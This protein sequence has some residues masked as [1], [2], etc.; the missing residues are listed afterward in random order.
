MEVRMNPSSPRIRTPRALG[1]GLLSATALLLGA[2][3]FHAHAACPP[4]RLFD[5]FTSYGTG[6]GPHEIVLD[7][8]NEDGILDLLTA[9]GP[10]NGSAPGAG[11]FTLRLGRGS[12]GVGDGSYGVPVNYPGGVRLRFV[13]AADFDEDGILDLAATDFLNSC[14]VVVRGQGTGGVGNGSFGPP[15]P[16]AVGTNPFGM[17]LG[18]FNEDGILDLAVM[19]N[20]SSNLSILLGLG[21]GGV[22]N[23]NFGPPT[24]YTL[25]T[26]PA[27]IATGDFNED[28]ITD[29]AAVVYGANRVS[30]LLGNGAGGVG[31]GTFAA[32]V[33]YTTGGQPFDVIAE[34]FNEDGIADLATGN[35]GGGLSILLGNGAG[36]VGNGTFA[37][38]T[39][40]SAGG[41]ASN[42]VAADW[43]EDGILD[44]ATINSVADAFTVVL[45]G[46]S[47]G[48]GD[49]TFGSGTNYGVGD[50]PD[51]L[52]ARDVNEDGHMDLLVSD[53]NGNDVR[54]FF[55]ACVPQPNLSNAPALDDVR[56]VR[57][58]QGGK[59]FVVW[60]R[61]VLDG[62]TGTSVTQYQ[63]WRRIAPDA[64]PRLSGA[65]RTRI[66]AGAITYWE[67][68]ATLPAHRL[69]GYGYTAATTRDSLPG[70]NPYTAFFVSAL[71]ADPNV[72]YDSNVD[73]G[74]SVDNLAPA[75]AAPFVGQWLPEGVALHWGASAAPDFARYEIHRGS[76]PSFVPSAGNLIAS[77]PDTGYVDSD[78]ATV[79]HYKL[80]V[81][82]VHEN[83]STAA[84]ASPPAA[85]PVTLAFHEAIVETGA[86]TLSWAVDRGVAMIATLE[87]RRATTDWAPIAEIV[88]DGQGN[89]VYTDRSV[90]DGGRYAYR[91][92]WTGAEGAQQSDEV[93]VDVP[94]Y[95]L[96]FA[97]RMPNPARGG[98]LP[99]ELTLASGGSGRLE[100]FTAT[101]RRVFSTSVDGVGPHRVDVG[102]GV[103]L[104]SG[105]YWLRLA[106]DGR[107]VR[108]KAVL[109]P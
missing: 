37:A 44:I 85:T 13:V 22:G 40:V 64:L 18:D 12:G 23:G 15:S 99:V 21:S 95:V 48:V 87:R 79:N 47:G 74:Y 65:V 53:Y 14:V 29:L 96:A 28:G 52:I 90:G 32:P 92:A 43:N 73:S 103:R 24:N 91:L 42:L 25:G 7:D 76:D 100:V 1:V 5:T 70:D 72:F 109:L 101:G 97:A 55:G 106:Q 88:P 20:G 49:G 57:A 93:W 94:G 82:D 26:N 67:N 38:A 104:A 69:P 78:G 46:G 83:R 41:V 58:D 60:R 50:V 66:D 75:Q 71:T 8:F 59:V 17:A 6:N 39:A 54:V 19:N 77:S 105:V 35:N 68:V 36:G 27:M 107:E 102:E 16:Y 98:R 45:G 31:N 10:L 9:N 51:D 86:A 61:S 89:L 2:T 3:P 108:T 30:I 84:L 56:D 4:G 34:D 80:V 11:M 81:V 62:D 33:P 63:V